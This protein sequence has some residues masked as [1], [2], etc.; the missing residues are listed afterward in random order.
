VNVMEDFLLHPALW[1]AVAL[2]VIGLIIY[3]VVVNNRREREVQELNKIF[4][5]GHLSREN[6]DKIPVEK[7]RR[8]TMERDRRK[9]E[10]EREIPKKMR[11]KKGAKVMVEEDQ[12]FILH[13]V[14]Q[15]AK[16]LKPRQTADIPTDKKPR[17][18]FGQETTQSTSQWSSNS[19]FSQTE[20]FSADRLSRANSSEQQF[21]DYANDD[22][23]LDDDYTSG[24]SGE[25]EPLA[26]SEGSFTSRSER[27]NRS[28]SKQQMS[29]DETG[30]RKTRSRASKYTTKKKLF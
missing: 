13:N 23:D 5:E 22:Y 18:P 1:I 4:P 14:N 17:T 11:P 6:L 15:H 16:P 8:N 9:Q 25:A 24:Y 29:A 2:I 7:V 21:D 27:S 3:S 26:R 12:E 19:S 28:R 20:S 10:R 30:E